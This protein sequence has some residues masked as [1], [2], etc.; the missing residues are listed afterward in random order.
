VRLWIEEKIRVL[1]QA[2]G[3]DAQGEAVRRLWVQS[4]KKIN[5]RWMIKDMEIQQYPEIHRTRLTVRDVK[6]QPPA[7]P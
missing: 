7:T 2:E 5:D 3:Y 6:P 4:C 1:L